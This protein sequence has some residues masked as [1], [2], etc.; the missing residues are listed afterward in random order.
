M[1]DYSQYYLLDPNYAQKI[2]LYFFE[3]EVKINYRWWNLFGAE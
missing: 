2:N 3:A 1:T